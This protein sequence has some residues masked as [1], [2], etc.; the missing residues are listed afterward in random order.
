MSRK[1]IVTGAG[2]GIG[3]A[4]TRRVLAEGHEVYAS[5]KDGARLA[6]LAR[7]LRT[8]KLHCQAV[9]VSDA[10]AVAQYFESL[11]KPPTDLVNNAGIYLGKPLNDYSLAEIDT[12]LSVN[13]RGAIL[14]SQLFGRARMKAKRSGVIVNL[15]SVSAFE[16]SS[17]PV[18]GTAKAA[19]A[20]LTRACAL[21]FAPYVR[22][23]AV[24]PG[25]VN[26]PLIGKIPG[27]RLKEF[28]QSE[29]LKDEIQPGDVADAVWFLLSD[30]SKRITG[31]ILDINNG[32]Y[33]R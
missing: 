14:F 20:G 19:L 3:E 27:W 26:T 13:V 30:A 31:S 9:D 32:G 33:F 7:K 15:S 23:N 24:A 4:I 18:Y 8:S 17:D 28:R 6:K 29:L 16:G 25:I 10:V 22:V 1:V 21:N 11:P 2:R 12:V 5:D